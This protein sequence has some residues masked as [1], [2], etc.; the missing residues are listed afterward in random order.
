MLCGRRWITSSDRRP[1]P[2]RGSP[3]RT[4]GHAVSTRASELAHRRLQAASPLLHDPSHGPT[5]T[6]RFGSA[7]P[8]D[9]HLTRD[10][11]SMPV[12]GSRPA[13]RTPSEISRHQSIMFAWVAAY[14]AMTNEQRTYQTVLTPRWVGL[15]LT[16]CCRR[17][18]V[19]VAV[20]TISFS[21]NASTARADVAYPGSTARIFYVALIDAPTQSLAYARIL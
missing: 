14:A 2:N 20:A 5:P 4:H 11:R 10:I 18:E 3:G 16:R 17:I 21:R 13:S 8:R 15:I 7:K 12:V 6:T 19:T 1:Y 9:P